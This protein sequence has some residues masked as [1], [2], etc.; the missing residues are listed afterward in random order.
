MPR[1]S[2]GKQAI[3]EWKGGGKRVGAEGEKKSKNQESRVA[4]LASICCGSK[5]V[6][7]TNREGPV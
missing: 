6:K 3:R 4:H 1:I 7:R 2:K 5:M